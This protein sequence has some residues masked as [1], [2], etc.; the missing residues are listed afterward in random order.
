MDINRNQINRSFFYGDL[1]FETIRIRQGMPM[2][3]HLHAARLNR[4]AKLLQFN[5]EE[6]REQ[7]IQAAIQAYIQTHALDDARLRLTLY[8]GGEGTYRFTHAVPQ[9]HI[10]SE[11]L[12]FEFS[13]CKTLGVY[14]DMKRM[15]H[16]ISTIKTGQA[17]TQVMAGIAAKQNVWDDCVVLNENGNVSCA[18]Q[19]NIFLFKNGK[20][21]TT[22][23]LQGGVC[24][25]M[26]QV[27]SDCCDLPVE[28]GTIT[29]NEMNDSEEIFLTNA[30]R[31]VSPV[32]AFNGRT[33]TSDFARFLYELIP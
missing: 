32:L 26:Q 25:I 29:L 11:P 33:L 2:F 10:H 18:I 4:G 15:I 31:K 9:L 21:K 14:T 3:L 20:L 16:P 17:L 12:Q 27:V 22:D 13:T 24:G 8:R 23:A 6:L 1:L 5:Q 28:F 7:E 30:I 19:S